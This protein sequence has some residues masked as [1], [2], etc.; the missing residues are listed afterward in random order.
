MNSYYNHSNAFVTCQGHGHYA[1][2]RMDYS[3]MGLSTVTNTDVKSGLI[4]YGTCK[5][6]FNNI[7]T[8]LAQSKPAPS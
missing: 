4:S 1:E 5:H 8:L 3:L 7:L 2:S 6:L